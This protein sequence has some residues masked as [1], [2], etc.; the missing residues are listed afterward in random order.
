MGLYNNVLCNRSWTLPE[1]SL[2]LIIPSMPYNENR[3]S[4][5]WLAQM[6]WRIPT[7]AYS[8]KFVLI[9]LNFIY[10]LLFSY[11]LVACKFRFSSGEHSSWNSSCIQN[12]GQP[13]KSEAQICMSLSIFSKWILPLNYIIPPMIDP[14]DTDSLCYKGF[15]SEINHNKVNWYCSTLK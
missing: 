8:L 10:I 5:V 11:F 14:T 6:V 12:S 7:I 13:E 3:I 9:F 15:L 2:P 1:W 4:P